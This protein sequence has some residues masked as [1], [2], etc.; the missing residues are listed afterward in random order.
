M[1]SRISKILNLSRPP[2]RVRV[3]PWTCCKTILSFMTGRTSPRIRDLPLSALLQLRWGR[4]WLLVG[5]AVC[6]A[7]MAGPPPSAP[8]APPA[9]PPVSS[10][11]APDDD[12]IEFLGAD[13]VGDAVWWEFLKKVPPR[14][15]T[16][17]ATPP[18]EV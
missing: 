5:V 13:D 11:G 6:S 3:T 10:P 1:V 14:G 7:A 12:F 16:P 17:P 8:P 9:P 4:R 2:M 15:G 18:Q